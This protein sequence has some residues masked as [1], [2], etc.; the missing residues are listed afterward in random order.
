MP[1]DAH[2][3]WK[4]LSPTDREAVLKAMARRYGRQ[5]GDKFRDIAEHGK[6]DLTLTYWQSGLAPPRSS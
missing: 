2:L 6:P 3:A 5:F 4:G 1:G